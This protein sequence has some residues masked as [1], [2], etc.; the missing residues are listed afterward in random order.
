MSAVPSQRWS[1]PASAHDES[2]RFDAAVDAL[3]PA[4]DADSSRVAELLQDN[5]ALA[6]GIG[7]DIAVAAMNAWPVIEKMA[8]GIPLTRAEEAVFPA[9]FRAL[10][11]AM[12]KREILVREAAED[13][14]R[15][16]RGIA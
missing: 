6:D 9:L 10:R 14:V 4:V 1:D 2:K 11:P 15:N 5:E 7:E 3:F 16:R 8:A 12:D 13:E